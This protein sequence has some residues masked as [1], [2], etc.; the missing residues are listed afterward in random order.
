MDLTVVKKRLRE[1]GFRGYLSEVMELEYSLIDDERARGI[2][3]NII[4]KGVEG[5]SDNQWHVFLKHGVGEINYVEE[6]ARCHMEIPWEE[7]LGA[8]W[9][10]EDDLCSYCHHKEEKGE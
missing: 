4:E 9:I 7:M 3:R 8:V 1:D 10:F 5:L 2:A 6:C